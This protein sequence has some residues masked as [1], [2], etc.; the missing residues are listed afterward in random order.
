MSQ[1]TFTF[2]VDEDLK[3]AFATVAE[4]NDRSGAQVLRDFMR[5][6]VQEHADKMTYD[7]WFQAKVEEGRRAAACG[8]VYTIAEMERDS[9]QLRQTLRD[10][11]NR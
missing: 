11:A 1:A 9:A 4:A 10:R 3:A 2:R 5:H 7:Q 6:Y 8:E